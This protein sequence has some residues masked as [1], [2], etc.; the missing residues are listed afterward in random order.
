[1]LVVFDDLP[2]FLLDGFTVKDKL[3]N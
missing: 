2:P 1:M 3:P